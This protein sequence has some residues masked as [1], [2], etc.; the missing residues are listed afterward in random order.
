M[1]IIKD[2]ITW[3]M[4]LLDINFDG[5]LWQNFDNR[6]HSCMLWKR[7]G[8]FLRNLSGL[9]SYFWW[10]LVIFSVVSGVAMKNLQRSEQ[11]HV[12]VLWLCPYSVDFMLIAIPHALMLQRDKN[13][14]FS[15]ESSIDVWVLS[16]VECTSLVFTL[17][18][19]CG[20]FC[21]HDP[22]N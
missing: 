15:P 11:V 21:A 13:A 6:Y 1:S 20:H 8:I 18:R 19:L 3:C 10:K 16:N 17:A 9:S 7:F 4:S 12:L 5:F 22:F 14:M 2:Q